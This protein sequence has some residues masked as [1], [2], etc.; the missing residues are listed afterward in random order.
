MNLNLLSKLLSI[1][2]YSGYELEMLDYIAS[3]AQDTCK[4]LTIKKN[5]KWLEVSNTEN[6]VKD[7]VFVVHVD[8][9][10]FRLK[11][12]KN[13]KYSLDTIGGTAN[14]SYLGAIATV[15]DHKGVISFDDEIKL[16]HQHVDTLNL[17]FDLLIPQGGLEGTPLIFEHLF[18]FTNT[19]IIGKGLDNKIGIYLASQ[20]LSE[21]INCSV[22]ISFLFT[23]E[24]ETGQ[25][26]YP[27]FLFQSELLVCID[28]F[29]TIEED[30]NRADGVVLSFSPSFDLIESKRIEADF[31]S[32]NILFQLSP[33]LKKTGTEIDIISQD[34]RSNNAP[35][36]IFSYPTSF[37]HSLNEVV[38]FEDIKHTQK[39]L[40]CYLKN[41]LNV[42]S[43]KE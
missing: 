29:S 35:Y 3:F 43:V 20:L 38:L 10:G 26:K 6:D 7:V 39:A 41:L 32:E 16:Y 18:Q 9:V 19:G 36:I 17:E 28:A 33:I 25:S 11:Q 27:D 24:E 2:S 23:T 31:V 5:D 21:A 4:G 8:E 30:C 14:A 13:N 40:Q 1:P 12:Q 22:N 42:L 15:N 37:M 34:P